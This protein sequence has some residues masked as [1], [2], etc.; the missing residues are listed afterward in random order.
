MISIRRAGMA[1]AVTISAIVFAACGGA[2]ATAT[3]TPVTAT[4]AI[5]ATPAPTATPATDATPTLPIGAIPSFD[6]SGLVQSLDGVDSYKVLITASGETQYSAIVVTRPVLSRDVTMGD[7]TRVV[8]IGDEAWI[9]TGDELQ[10]APPEMATPMLAAFDPILLV[11]AFSAPGAMLGATEVGMEEKNGVQARHF[12]VAGDSF[13]GAT[14]A[15]PP[16]SSIEMWV[17]EEGY[18]VSMS[19]AGAGAGTFTMD[20]TDVNDSSNIVERPS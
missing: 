18:L 17:A 19:I 4:P 10:P 6:L 14:A 2:A 12:T 1:G 20:V 5:A 3:P 13:V 16:G 8:V 11:G 15:L 7:D 9:G